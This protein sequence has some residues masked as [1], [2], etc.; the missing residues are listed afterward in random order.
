MSLGVSFIS[1]R[2]VR[3]L[4][5]RKMLGQTLLKNGYVQQSHRDW[6]KAHCIVHQIIYAAVEKY[7]PVTFQ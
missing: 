3:S 1:F 4:V 7:I 5:V 2:Q 6:Q